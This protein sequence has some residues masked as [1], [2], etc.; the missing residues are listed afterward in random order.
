MSVFP[1]QREKLQN[2]AVWLAT[3]EL[4][5]SHALIDPDRRR[6]AHLPADSFEYLHNISAAEC[7]TRFQRR[8]ERENVSTI[9]RM[10]S[11][12]PVASW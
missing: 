9:V 6:E 7:E 3:M 4:G 5:H 10:R 8:G 2:P 11:F 1:I 12:R